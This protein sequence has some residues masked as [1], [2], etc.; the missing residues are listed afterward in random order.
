MVIS[1]AIYT[2]ARNRWSFRWKLVYGDARGRHMLSQPSNLWWTDPNLIWCCSTQRS[3]PHLVFYVPKKWHNW[4]WCMVPPGQW[5]RPLLL[6]DICYARS[7][8]NSGKRVP[9]S[10]MTFEPCWN[11]A[12]W[13]LIYHLICFPSRHVRLL[14]VIPGNCLCYS[15]KPCVCYLPLSPPGLMKCAIVFESQFVKVYFSRGLHQ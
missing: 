12:S 1:F 13:V 11:A 9:R 6:G 2:A 3:F 4:S 14:R 8:S 5:S 15:P 7:C 10:R